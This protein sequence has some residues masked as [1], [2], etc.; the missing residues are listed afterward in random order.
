MDQPVSVRQ[1]SNGSKVVITYLDAIQADV[2][3]EHPILFRILNKLAISVQSVRWYAEKDPDAPKGEQ[4]SATDTILS[5]LQAVLD[6]PND[7]MTADQ[8]R[9]WMTLSFASYARSC[10]LVTKSSMGKI[11]GLWPLDAKMTSI[12]TDDRGVVT[13]YKYGVGDSAKV[14]PSQRKAEKINGHKPFVYE[15]YIPNLTGTRTRGS[16]MSPL[17]ALGLPA[18]IVSLLLQRAV[19]SAGGHP[20]SKYIVVAE[21]SLTDTQKDEIRDHLENMEPGAEES[22]NV[23]FVYNTKVEVVTLDNNLG[24]IHS[25]VPLDDMARMMAGVYGIPVSLLGLAAAD[26]AKFAGNYKESRRSFWED[27]IIPSYLEPIAIAMTRAICPPGVR[28]AFDMDAIP[29]L[30]DAR[31][32][33][34]KNLT[35][36]TFWTGDE[37]RLLTGFPP[38]GYELPSAIPGVESPGNTPPKEDEDNED[39]SSAD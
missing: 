31:V 30:Q 26:G 23:I 15:M 37:K 36:V 2:A 3:L 17:S 19:D 7:D 4:R 6:S 18:K 1:L 32:E 13:D 11:N 25:K 35:F 27:T 22:G 14:Y 24:D 8:F 5:D 34:A 12:I 10:F 28:I 9:Y 21:R 33:R 29:A 38:L 16:N 39:D 20:N